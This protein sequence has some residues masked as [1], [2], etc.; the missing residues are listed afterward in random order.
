MGSLAHCGGRVRGL[1]VVLAGSRPGWPSS[2]P[3]A[4]IVRAVLLENTVSVGSRNPRLARRPIPRIWVGRRD[5]GPQGLSVVTPPWGD[6][7]PARLGHLNGAPTAHGPSGAP[8]PPLRG[9]Q[10][11]A[12]RRRRCATPGARR[13]RDATDAGGGEDEIHRVSWGPFELQRGDIGEAE[14]RAASHRPRQHISAGS[15]GQPCGDFGWPSR[16]RPSSRRP[17]AQAALS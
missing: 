16:S 15:V 4:R 2:W 11:G 8:P 3:L 13:S 5:R 9:A 10:E 7:V 17:E 12:A 14:S 1:R 6:G